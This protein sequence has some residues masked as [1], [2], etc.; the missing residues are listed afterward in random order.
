MPGGLG[1][2]RRGA[3]LRQA[4]HDVDLQDPGRRA[5]PGTSRSTRAK[6][7]Q[8]RA[9]Q[10]ARRDLG[11]LRADLGGHGELRGARR[12][13]GLEVVAVVVER[14]RLDR[15]QRLAAQHRHGHLAA[16]DPALAEHA[17][18]VGQGR[19]QRRRQRLGVVDAAQAEAGAAARRLDDER[20]ADALG[21][22][23]RAAR[24]RRGRARPPTRR[25]RT[26]A[27][28]R[29]VAPAARAWPRSCRTPRAASGRAHVRHT[30]S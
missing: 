30:A 4:G 15:R 6:A 2:E 17:V 13:A 11:R 28:G 18:V 10:A 14:D 19:Q 24:R 9:R 25:R 7:P 20:P 12:V 3:G 27:V 16:L 26:A 22:R 8:P 5:R 21:R 23:G 1:G 29:P